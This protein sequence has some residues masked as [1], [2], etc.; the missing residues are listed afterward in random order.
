M[1]EVLLFLH[2]NYE[3][4][5]SKVST[6]SRSESISSRVGIWSQTLWFHH[7]ALTIMLTASE[8]SKH[9]C[10]VTLWDS[11]KNRIESKCVWLWSTTFFCAPNCLSVR[12]MY[13]AKREQ[14]IFTDGSTWASTKWR[15]KKLPKHTPLHF[16]TSSAQMPVANFMTQ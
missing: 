5:E 6:C 14:G 11:S 15:Q 13:R 10:T 2:S 12:L 3:E 16:L 9:K 7:Q 4:T 1:G 8:K